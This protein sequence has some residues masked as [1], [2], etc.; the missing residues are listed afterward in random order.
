MTC[1]RPLAETTMRDGIYSVQDETPL[2]YKR[3]APA[4]VRLGNQDERE[5]L[6]QDAQRESVAW[7]QRTHE[8]DENAEDLQH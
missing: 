4:P 2:C 5:E 6:R 8:Y 7:M 3:P 1:T